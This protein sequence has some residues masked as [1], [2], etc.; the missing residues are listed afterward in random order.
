VSTVRVVRRCFGIRKGLGI[1]R[2]SVRPSFVRHVVAAG[3][4][5]TQAAGVV[6][7]AT[8]PA[9][10]RVPS[11][12]SS[13]ATAGSTPQEIIRQVQAA[14]VLSAGLQKSDAMVAAASSRLE[15]LS[16]QANTLSANLPATW[17][18][19][20]AAETEAAAQRARLFELGKQVQVAR[21]A[22]G[23]RASDSY[24]GDGG[25]SPGDMAA[26]L[27]ALTAPAPSQGTDSRSTVDYLANSRARLLIR[28]KATQSSQ[29][30]TSTEAA[31]TSSRAT[32]AANTAGQSKSALDAEI[33]NQQGALKGLRATEAAQVGQ[34]AGVRSTL[35]RSGNTWELATDRQ[36]AQTLR[37]R[38]YSLLMVQSARCSSGSTSYSNG[39]WPSSAR[40]ALYAAPDQSLRRAAALAFDAM[41]NAYQRQTGSALCVTEGY[42]SYA[43]QVAVKQRLPGLA[44]TPGSSKHG[45][46]LAV[47]LCG[48]VQDFANPAHLWLKRNASRFGWF[49]PAWA[50]PSGGLPEPWHWEFGG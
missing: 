32:A 25:G 29:A 24:I 41:S 2:T 34:A 14:Q 31:A 49:H 47:D 37:G 50:E 27:L 3:L 12:P 5:A 46:G 44:A 7:T 40:C 45:L 26:D 16:A 17:T 15:A 21:A 43:E 48:G 39:W 13:L 33:I 36:L 10:A 38:D 30:T 19:Q 4:A 1:G 35:L 6:L 42:R 28:L 23:Q 11:R 8:A 22:L 20:V 18:A 9:S